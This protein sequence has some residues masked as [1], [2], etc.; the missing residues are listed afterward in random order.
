MT[1]EWRPHID[2]ARLTAAL[3]AEILAA[4]ELELRVLLADPAVSAAATTQ[5]VRD[6]IAE[7]LGEPTEHKSALVQLDR[8]RRSLLAL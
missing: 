6:V 8:Q 2:L 4:P 5:D 1:K 3:G 7:A